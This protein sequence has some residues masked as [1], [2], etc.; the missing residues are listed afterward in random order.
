MPNA[1]S[2]LALSELL[3]GDHKLKPKLADEYEKRLRRYYNAELTALLAQF[4][5]LPE[6]ERTEEKLLNL[7]NADKTSA[8]LARQ[9]ITLWYTAQFNVPDGRADA[10]KTEEQYESS[11]LWKVIKAHPPGH[12][13]N[14]VYGH[15]EKKP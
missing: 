2:F 4:D 15:W 6:K 10:P 11:L 13:N 5:P 7:L 1:N 3:T 9:V 8:R 12:T 14:P